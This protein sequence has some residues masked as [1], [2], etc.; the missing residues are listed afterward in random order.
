MSLLIGRQGYIG[1]A[2]ES[3]AGT[4][5]STPAVFLPTTENTIDDKHEKIMDISTRASRIKDHDSV[6]GKQWSEGDLAMY[7]DAN[8]SGY[9][10]KLAL[11]NEVKTDVQA[12]PNVDNH[13]FY[14]TASGNSPKTATVWNYRGT[15]PAIRQMNRV[16]VDSLEMEVTN[17]GLATLTTAFM[18][19]ES[20]EVSAPTLTT[21]SGTV[22]T[23]GDATVK[24][25]DTI[26][27]AEG[28]TATKVT[29]F[30]FT[31]NNNLETIFRTGSRT[32][33]EITMGEAEVLGEY[34]L[35]FEDDTEFNK[36][37]NNTKQSMVVTL[38]GAS[39]GGVSEQVK[40][41]FPRIILDDKEVDTGQADL[42]AITANF[43]AINDIAGQ[44]LVANLQN[45]KATVY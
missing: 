38:T 18:G 33:D 8:N 36:Y 13:Q 9:L 2:I 43:R 12:S 26:A 23:W 24:F 22:L 35:F 30:K 44:I 25:G 39:L 3:V 29:N 5:E 16:A 17:D 10:F 7:L 20:S 1:M 4:P 15:G 34:T 28:N 32:L 14:V 6:K 11:G 27:A 21:A 31:L 45:T 41:E 40:L 37:L 42:F 19:S